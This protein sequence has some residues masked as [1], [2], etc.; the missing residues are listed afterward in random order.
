MMMFKLIL[1]LKIM[2]CYLSINILLSVRNFYYLSFLSHLLNKSI[3]MLV[4][5]L[6]AINLICK[7][8]YSLI[9]LLY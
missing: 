8:K 9:L 5:L 1:I 2:R 4:L 3:Q 6:I 7:F